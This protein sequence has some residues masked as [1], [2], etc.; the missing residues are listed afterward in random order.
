MGEKEREREMVKVRKSGGRER[1]REMEQVG[2]SKEE[3]D[4]A[5]TERERE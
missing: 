1:D 5:R 2:Q 4:G 3:R